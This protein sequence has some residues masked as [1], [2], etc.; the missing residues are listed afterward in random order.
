MEQQ[1][2]ICP[3]GASYY[4]WRSGDT[5]AS[6]ARGNSTTVQAIRLNNPGVDFSTIAVGTEIC[7]PSRSLTCQSGQPYTVQSGETLS[8]IAGKLGITE[9]ALSERNPDITDLTGGDVICIPA[10]STPN[11]PVQDGTGSDNNTVAPSTPLQ[12]ITP[13]NPSISCPVGYQAHRVQAGQTYADLLT[14]LNVSY[15]AMRNANPSLRPG[16]LVAGSLYCAPP[17]GTREVCSQHRSYAVQEGDTLS[18]IAQAQ[19]TTPGRLLMANPTLLPT[20]FSQA[21]T[22]I[23]I[24]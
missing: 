7:L 18:S 21:G 8:S 17:A 22:I 19:N 23:C 20:D 15:K 4:I 16:S 14:S 5:L 13:M 12:P 3:R 1:N 24:L 11:S 6:V 2:R 10:E 9:L